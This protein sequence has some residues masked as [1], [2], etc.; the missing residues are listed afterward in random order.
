[1]SSGTVSIREQDG[2][3]VQLE[4]YETLPSVARLAKKY[5]EKGYPDR[6]A[7]FSE[8]QMRSALTGSKLNESETEYGMFLS[9]ILRP[10][11]FPSQA[12]L[13]GAMT[14]TA[15]AQGLQEHTTKNLGIG[16]VSDIYCDGV[17]IGAS[18]LEGKLDNFTTYEYIIVNFAAKLDSENFPPMLADMV[19]KVFE[20]E[21]TSISMIIARSI[22]SKFLAFYSTFK[23]NNSFMDKY[24][25]LF[26]LRGQRIRHGV[27]QKKKLCKVLGV[28]METGALII[29]TRS[30]DV[31]TVTSP[32][33]VTIPKRIR[34]KKPVQKK[35][36]QKE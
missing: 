4:I 36:Q 20:S 32:T 18:S 33:Q 26:V 31:K 35:Q 15:M 22:L 3:V 8:R 28:D 2:S 24:N 11:I 7:V 34:L 29:A 13:L 12:A 9:L 27:D 6:Y 10:S 5:A 25:E 23:T 30:G 19:R 14:A 1:M 21:N 17:K 16:W